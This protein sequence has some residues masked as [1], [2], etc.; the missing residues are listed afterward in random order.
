MCLL[1][2]EDSH[3]YDPFS[4]AT[5]GNRITKP[6]MQRKEQNH[7]YKATKYPDSLGR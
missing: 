7:G 4:P 1:T 6:N 5:T 2:R 3:R